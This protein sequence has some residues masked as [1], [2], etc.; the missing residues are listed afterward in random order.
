MDVALTFPSTPQK[1]YLGFA[2]GSL[3]WLASHA[4]RVP[5]APGQPAYKWPPA[6]GE[7]ADDA[8][9]TIGRGAAGIGRAFLH[10]FEG[11]GDVAYRNYAVGAA[12]W[13][14]YESTLEREGR[15]W[16][17]TENSWCRGQLGLT[18]FLG[19]VYDLTHS[20]E[21]GKAY[22]EGCEWL[23]HVSVDSEFG[24][25][26]PVESTVD[27]F[28]QSSNFYFGPSAISS[29]H[30][31]DRPSIWR[32]QPSL[33]M[34]INTLLFFARSTM[35]VQPDQYTWTLHIPFD[36]YEWSSTGISGPP[37]HPLDDVIQPPEV[38]GN[39]GSRHRDRFSVTP[40]PVRSVATLHFDPAS[41]LAERGSLRVLPEVIITDVTGRRMAT[42]D[43]GAWKA[44]G[45]LQWTWDARQCDVYPVTQG[46]YYAQVVSEGV[47]VSEAVSIPFVR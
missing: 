16:N 21:Y 14:L 8:E 17:I 23:N 1:N 37:V 30:Y 6:E 42:L 18:L 34:N 29:F 36:G 22:L 28:Y 47:A 41:I 26:F 40:I 12:N 39:A 24:T 19:N 35:V 27:E 46:M 4:V 31:T 13:L 11:L 43:P 10:G 3:D 38:R 2:R 33:R 25:M 44:D 5:E 9:Y 7:S 20:I 45:S 32:I 15:H